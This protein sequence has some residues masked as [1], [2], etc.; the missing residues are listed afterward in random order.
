MCLFSQGFVNNLIDPEYVRGGLLDRAV[1][2]TGVIF[3]IQRTAENDTSF[4]V[5]TGML[6]AAAINR[7]D[8]YTFFC[9]CNRANT[10]ELHTS[11]SFS[12]SG[13]AVV[14]MLLLEQNENR[15]RVETKSGWDTIFQS[16]VRFKSL[17]TFLRLLVF[18]RENMSLDC[19]FTLFQRVLFIFLVGFPVPKTPV[20]AK[21]TV[22][23]VDNIEPAIFGTIAAGFFSNP[24]DTNRCRFFRHSCPFGGGPDLLVQR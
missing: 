16:F 9:L 21:H 3:R 6:V 19:P 1:S 13:V 14:E 15:M 11:Y 12:Y 2:L 10:S 7:V 18:T 4:H 17:P 22:V 20:I 24:F 23:H 8:L 5:I